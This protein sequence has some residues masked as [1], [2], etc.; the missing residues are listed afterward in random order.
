[1][2]KIVHAML[3]LNGSSKV[4][5]TYLYHNQPLNNIFLL[6]I[7][8]PYNSILPNTSSFFYVTIKNVY[9]NPYDYL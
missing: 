4:Y 7:Q 9:H 1:M 3:F 8:E 2:T 6:N 5:N